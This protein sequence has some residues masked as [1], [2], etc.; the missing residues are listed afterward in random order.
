VERRPIRCIVTDR[1]VTAMFGGKG[2]VIMAARS[3]T[4]RA[5]A[6]ENLFLPGRTMPAAMLSHYFRFDDIQD[7]D[8]QE[9]GVKRKSGR[10]PANLK[11]RM[12]ILK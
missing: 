12:K 8:I 10:W 9:V 11:F 1:I 5:K 4:V 6:S 2:H 3:G 7:D